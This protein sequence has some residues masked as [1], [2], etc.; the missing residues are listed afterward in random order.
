M[1]KIIHGRLNPTNVLIASDGTVKICDFCISKLISFE[2][3]SITGG[4]IAKTFY[5]APEI[6]NE[7]DYYDEKVDV[8]SFGTLVFFILSG[9]YHPKIKINDRVKG[10]KAEIPSSFTEFSKKLINECWNF[11]PKDRPSFQMILDDF[12]RNHYNLIKLNKTEI[13]NIDSFVKQ[14][15]KKDSSMSQ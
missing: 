12:E 4:G 10:K 9:G 3:Q 8:Y 14:H 6:L 2:E 11:N 15:K 7:E 1:K 13:E 5:M